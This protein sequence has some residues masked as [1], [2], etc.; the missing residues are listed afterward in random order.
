[1]PHIPEERVKKTARKGKA[2]IH[3]TLQA[4]ERSENIFPGQKFVGDHA[5]FGECDL[6]LQSLRGG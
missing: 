2:A 1:M 5:C 4:T 3:E 6:W